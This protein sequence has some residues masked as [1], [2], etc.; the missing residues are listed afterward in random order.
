MIGESYP[1]PTRCCRACDRGGSPT[2][3]S[4]LCM[5][6]TAWL[7]ADSFHND[8]RHWSKVRDYFLWGTLFNCISGLVA[9]YIVAIDVTRVRFPADAF[10][11]AFAWKEMEYF[12]GGGRVPSEVCIASTSI[13]CACGPTIFFSYC[14]WRQIAERGFDPRTFGL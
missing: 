10:F 9:E 5:V 4:A 1:K 7:R 6:Q 2:P 13:T 8:W 11:C 3:A 12:G 14:I